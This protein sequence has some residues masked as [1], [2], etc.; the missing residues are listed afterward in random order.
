MRAAA[1]AAHRCPAIAAHRQAPT[2][3]LRAGPCQQW[4]PLVKAMTEKFSLRMGGVVGTRW[5]CEVARRSG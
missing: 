2:V 4:A 3:M 1:A 5:A